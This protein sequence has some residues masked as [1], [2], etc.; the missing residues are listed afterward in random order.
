MALEVNSKSIEYK[1]NKV[2]IKSMPKDGENLSVFIRPGDEVVFDIDGVTS[3]EL[4]YAL[5]GGDIVVE[6]PGLGALT[7]PSMGLMSFSSNPPQFNFSGKL[8]SVE[9]LLSKIQEINELPI[10]SVDASF[11]VRVSDT[12][13]DKGLMH[14][15]PDMASPAPIIIVPQSQV[16]PD[17][18]NKKED[19]TQTQQEV[20]KDYRSDSEAIAK[21]NTVPN[22]Y[23]K[24]YASYA[25]PNDFD[26]YKPKEEM[27]PKPDVEMI[28]KPDVEMIPKPDYETMPKNDFTDYFPENNYTGYGDGNGDGVGPGEGIPSFGFKATAHQVRFSEVLNADNTPEILGGGGSVAGYKFDSVSDQYKPETIDISNRTENMVIRAENSDYFSNAPSAKTGVNVLTFKDLANGESVTIDGLTLT[29]SGAISAAA[30]ATGFASLAASSDGILNTVTN[31][32]WSGTLSAGWS[33]AAAAGDKVTFT[34]TAANNNITTFVTSSLGSTPVDVVH[35]EPST[36][37]YLSR[38]L[39]FEPNMPEGF[40]VDSFSISGLPSGVKIL[41]KD[42][43]EISGSNISKENMIFKNA[44]GEVIAYDSVDFLTN[45]KSAEFTIKYPNNISAPFNV[46]ITANY[47]VD[48]AFADSVTESEQSFTNEYTFALKD[49]TSADDYTYKK[50][51]FA[52]GKDEGFILSKE[53]NYNI[54]KDGSGDNIIYGGIVKDVVYDAAGDD[55]YYLSAGDDTLYG[56]SGTNRIYGDNDNGS[57]ETK[58]YDGKDTVSYENVNS[59]GI[60]EIELLS[61]EGA[62]TAQESQKL[63]GSYDEDSDPSTSNPL[64]VDMLVSYKGV[65]VDLDGVH[66]DGLNIDV[67]GDGDIDADDKINAISKFA[68]R[69]GR[70]T[71]DA[72]GYAIGT[73]IGKTI[74]FTS[75][76]SNAQVDDITVVA[77]GVETVAAPTA[78]G[79]VSIQGVDAT[80]TESHEITFQD[81]IAGQSVTVD[82][83]KLTAT[84]AISAADVAAGFSSLDNSAATAGSA[85]TNG[86]WS[87]AKTTAWT[88]GGATGAVVTFTSQ[89][90]TT[91]VDDIVTAS[92]GVSGIDTPAIDVAITQGSSDIDTKQSEKATIVFKDLIAGQSLSVGGLTLSATG[93][94]SAASVAAGFASLSAGA[95]AGNAVANGTWSGTLG[96]FSSSKQESG[97]DSI[98]AT[99]Y[100]IYKDIENITGSKYNDTIYGNLTKDNTLSGLGGSDTIDGRG[101]NNKLYGGDG[102]DTLISGSGKDYIDGG[103]DTDTVSYVNMIEGVR[104]RLDRP[105]GEEY[106]YA[107]LNSDLVNEKDRILNVEN[108]TGSSYDDTIYGNANTNF[109]KGGAGDDRIF[110]GGG[111]DFIDGGAGSDWITYKPSDYDFNTTKPSFMETFQGITVD[112]NSS[113]FVMV[114]ETATDNLIDLIKDIEK[115]SATD[116]IDK[117]YGSNS[118]DEEFW[119]WGGNDI[120]YGRGGNDILHGGSGDDYIRP[121]RGVDKSYGDT[122]DN[123]L[124]LYDDGVKDKAFQAIRLNSDGKVQHKLVAG[125][126]SWIDGYNS[127]DGLEIAEGFSGI[128]LGNGTNDEIHGNELANII[129]GYGGDDD[130]YGYG[131]DDTIRGGSGKDKIYGGAGK[132]IIYGDQDDDTIDAGD[133][134]DTVYGYGRYTTGQTNNDK[135]DGGDGFD[136]IDYSTTSDAITLNLGNVVGGYATVE[137]LSATGTAGIYNDLIKNFESVVGSRGNDTITANDSGMTLDGWSGVD[138]LY[139]GAG[140]DTIIARNQATEILDGGGG[141]DT[142]KLAQNVDFRNQTISNFEILELGSYNSYFNLSQW[143]LNSFT[144]VVGGDN[145]RIYMYSTN[146]VT[147]DNFNFTNID[148][149]DFSGSLYVSGYNGNDTYNFTGSTLSANM[150]F[151]L[152]ASSGTDT[153]IMGVN[154]TINMLDNYYNT[155]ETFQIGT[156]SNLNIKAYNDNGRTFYAH[157]KDFSAVDG[158]VNLIGGSGNDTFYANYEALLAG[159]LNIDGGSGSDM[160]DVRTTQTNAALTFNDADIF[161]NIERLEL[162]TIS[163][164]NSINIDARAMKQ[165]I[166]S[167]SELTLDIANNTQGTKV[168]IDNTKG[169][170]MTNFTIGQSYTI[171]LDDNTSFAMHVV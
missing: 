33:S 102:G 100:D 103:A 68:N 18:Y 45:F 119:G 72:D 15:K 53:P 42:S 96:S 10:T 138:K 112:L 120:L 160:V 49:I 76:T 114:K 70:F 34:S 86:T 88:S 54:I 48:A 75:I 30:V 109:I 92:A 97:L 85:V 122:G 105:N 155:F 93:A 157:N 32:A 94:I 131:G 74:T 69:D 104:V 151:Y 40:Y 29:A 161:N 136:T 13:E 22:S 110:A 128:G 95:T 159:K 113:D 9:N 142:L 170:D 140:A 37:V 111:Y 98:Q 43:N 27:I 19:F 162:D 121:G 38:V 80:T 164:T 4:D 20:R 127:I 154:Q 36:D 60:S 16:L 65:Y 168:T 51:D 11:K 126:G 124:E 153:L 62:I 117:I 44:L 3:D 21:S 12:D 39:R 150:N 133:G 61:N 5:V 147:D 71:Y 73:S 55:T 66:V 1:D 64:N 156:D 118:A 23:T 99:G 47:K 106:D 77:S 89:T 171:T 56:G 91:A 50:A 24:P 165:W 52:G 6:F 134:D 152:D 148:F 84:G 57:A 17:S 46:S 41:D 139:G 129:N 82:G 87:G 35:S 90:A 123:Y 125:D 14:N 81:L 2:I 26:A 25:K 149:S 169:D 167:S 108:I 31:G 132:D 145:S 63:G 7:F 107:H 158:D 141:S 59:F 135:I 115:I 79:V 28:P 8:F 78:L 146:T 163:S 143:S 83:L 130:I 58:K 137:F 166:G 101:G 116:G 144:K 67:D